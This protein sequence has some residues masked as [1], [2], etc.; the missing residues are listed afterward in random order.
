MGYYLAMRRKE[1]LLF[2]V[3]WTDLEVIMQSEISQQKTND[4]WYHLQVESKKLV[5][6]E[7]GI[8]V[9][10]NGYWAVEETLLKDTNL[11]K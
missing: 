3:T 4:V 1:I 9:E 7:S 5:K 2:S 10:S 8:V 6:T 11:H